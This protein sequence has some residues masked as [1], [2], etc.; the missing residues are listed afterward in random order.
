MTVKTDERGRLYLSK[1]LR[2]RYGQ[3]YHVVEYADHIELIPVSDDPLGSLR[4]NVG[5]ALEGQSLEDLRA[6]AAEQAR[7]DAAEHLEN[8]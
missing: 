5:S 7:E 4:E 8:R 6:A 2:E 1:D 3:T